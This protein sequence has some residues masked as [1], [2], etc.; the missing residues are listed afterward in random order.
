MAHRAEYE[1]GAQSTHRDSSQE[2]HTPDSQSLLTQTPLAAPPRYSQI[3]HRSTGTRTRVSRA[4]PILNYQRDNQTEF[5][6]NTARDR[7]AGRSDEHTPEFSPE[8]VTVG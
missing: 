1:L 3:S 4:V 7:G 5:Y 2:D 8:I 6:D